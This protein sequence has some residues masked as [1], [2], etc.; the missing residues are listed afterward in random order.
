MAYRRLRTLAIAAVIALPPT[1]ALA[2]TPVTLDV[3]LVDDGFEAPLFVASPPDD[4]RLF[5]VD[6]SGQIW[7]IADGERLAEPF[8]DIG[9]EIVFGGEQGLLGLAFHPDYAQ[10]GRF[11]IN[12][13]T[14]AG[15][16]RVAEYR[17]SEDPNVADPA[18]GITLIELDDRRGNH[19]G[20]WMDFG[21]DGY[22]YIS[23]GDGGGGGDPDQNGQNPNT[24]FGKILRIDVDRGSPYGIPAAN[25]FATGGGA[26]EVF[27]LGLRNAWRLAFDDDLLYVA[28]V[29]QNI[30][31]EVTVITTGDAGANLGWNIMEGAHCFEA[32][33][34]DQT[35][36]VLPVHEYDHDE[37]CSITGGYVYRGSAIPAITGHYFFA[38]Y[39]AG[40]VRSFLY[41]DGAAT[42]VVDWTGQLGELGN[43]TSFGKD[44]A[45]E[46]YITSSNGSVYRIVPGG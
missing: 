4:P 44:A 31:E 33:N 1:L 46:L 39:C 28:D 35:G 24:L 9:D 14:A 23:N 12:H 6:Q 8:L 36:L 22:L 21:P 11:F 18:S 26:P 27:A 19:N 3:Q 16:T 15:D 42:N 45:G 2:Q 13:T 43:I 25:P 20:G 41:Q 5:V 37:G 29:G 40:F 10:N 7:V 38:D 17:V 34:C 32:N 30:W